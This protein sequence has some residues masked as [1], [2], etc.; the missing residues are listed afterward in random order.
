MTRMVPEEGDGNFGLDSKSPFVLRQ[1]RIFDVCGGFSI[2]ELL[3][4]SI[5][6]ELRESFMAVLN[7]ARGVLR[8][9]F[10]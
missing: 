5:L 2:G 9:A 8:L 7:T 4:R 1:G 10:E 6:V 3:S